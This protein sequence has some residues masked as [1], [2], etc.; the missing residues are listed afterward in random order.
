MSSGR[1]AGEAGSGSEGEG[2]QVGAQSPLAEAT[3]AL[4]FRFFSCQM[5]E[6]SDAQLP[7]LPLGHRALFPLRTFVYL[8]KRP[9]FLLQATYRQ[10]KA[11]VCSA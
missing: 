7:K 6:L 1:E 5:R 10:G 2:G 11:S 4:P 8:L 3:L 9:D